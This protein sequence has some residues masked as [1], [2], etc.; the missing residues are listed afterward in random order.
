M[1]NELFDAITSLAKYKVFSIIAAGGIG[2]WVWGNITNNPGMIS[3]AVGL[4]VLCM[5]LFLAYRSSGKRR[6]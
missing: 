1:G 3:N 6:A 4:L 5:V 2:V